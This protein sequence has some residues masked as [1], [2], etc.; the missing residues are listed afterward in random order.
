[1]TAIHHML[2]PLPL[3][4]WTLAALLMV[5]AA[6]GKPE[7]VRRAL[8]PLLLLGVITGAAATVTGLLS[9]DFQS[10]VSS[11][12]SR[13]KIAFAVWCLAWWSM[14]WAL[15]YAHGPRLYK[16]GRAS[17]MVI[18]GFI[19]LGL[20]SLTGFLGGQLAGVTTRLTDILNT[21]G[22]E[23]YTT[24]RLPLWALIVLSVIIFSWIILALKSSGTE[25]VENSSI[26]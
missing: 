16:K 13:N 11:P 19:G 18:L 17:V 26:N 3:G 12:L 2:I 7:W 25:A 24:I 23:I 15:H 1:M 4:I 8:Q 6:R 9:W 10:L 20:A 5:F 21:A 22:F 14:L